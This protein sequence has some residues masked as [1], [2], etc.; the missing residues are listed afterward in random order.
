MAVASSAFAH[1]R[2]SNFELLN[3]TCRDGPLVRMGFARIGKCEK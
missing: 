1:G 2:Q 3:A